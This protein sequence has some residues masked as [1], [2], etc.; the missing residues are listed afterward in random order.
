MTIE[1][2]GVTIPGLSA[3]VATTTATYTPI[4]PLSVANGDTTYVNPT[5]VAGSPVG[6][7][8]V[9]VVELVG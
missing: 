3:L 4:T 8:L 1:Q 7:S 6:L 2:N 5:A 9:F